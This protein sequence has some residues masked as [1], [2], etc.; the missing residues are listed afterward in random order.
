MNDLI[1]RACLCK[2][3]LDL[4]EYSWNV[5]QQYTHSIFNFAYIP[6][7]TC[8]P[9]HTCSKRK[10]RSH[11]HGMSRPHQI[12]HFVECAP[13][14]Y[15]TNLQQYVNMFIQTENSDPTSMSV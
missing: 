9:T 7:Y 4:I 11:V 14:I 1:P 15:T 8:I 3:Y 5:H 10:T 13:A 12:Y 6:A 2:R